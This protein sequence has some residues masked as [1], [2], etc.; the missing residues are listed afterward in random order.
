MPGSFFSIMLSG[1]L[2]TFEK[3]RIISIEP[4]GDGTRITLEASHSSEE[5][6]VYD[7]SEPYDEV[8]RAYLS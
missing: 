3:K 4:Y 5:P 6:L 2:T 7:S 1:E 8:M